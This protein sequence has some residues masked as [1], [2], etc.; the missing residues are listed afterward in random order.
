MIYNQ[1]VKNL[2]V[3]LERF[4]VFGHDN[5]DV[6]CLATRDIAPPNVTSALMTAHACGLA[7]VNI[8]VQN[9]LCTETTRFHDRLQQSKSPT[10]K[11]MYQVQSKSITD[12]KEKTIKADRALFQ[13]LL[14]SKDAGREVDLKEILSHELSPFPLSLAD[15]TG[16][17]KPTNKAVL[18]NILQS[19]TIVV[20]NSTNRFKDVHYN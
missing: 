20:G 1:D 16:Q 18:G 14:V 9:R 7:K 11:T 19:E 17:L 10:L 12:H 8:F 5:T 3:Q 13:Q 15:M 2:I 6:V 4:G